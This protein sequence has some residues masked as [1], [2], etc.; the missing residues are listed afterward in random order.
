MK[1]KSGLFALLFA[2]SSVFA[3]PDITYVCTHDTD[4]RIIKVV[5]FEDAT[6][7]CEVE[8]NKEEGVSSLWRANNIE[9]YCEEKAALFVTKHES[10]GWDCEIAATEVAEP[11]VIE[12][13]P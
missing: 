2:S 3:L 13:A 7:P 6:L 11:A 5:Y 9:G 1:I 12:E 4:V 8:Y 10:W